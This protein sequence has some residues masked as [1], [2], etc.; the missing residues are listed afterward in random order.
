MSTSQSFFKEFLILLEI[1]GE[2]FVETFG[3]LAA[4]WWLAT[5][6]VSI[7]IN[8]PVTRIAQLNCNW[9][10]GF[11]S[12][13]NIIL[14]MT[15]FHMKCFSK[16]VKRMHLVTKKNQ[17]LSKGSQIKK[18]SPLLE[19]WC[20]WRGTLQCGLCYTELHMCAHA[21]LTL[22]ND[23]MIVDSQGPLF[24]QNNPLHSGLPTQ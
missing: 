14:E 13:K 5:Y 17:S 18:W 10:A 8:L 1:L 12:T 23:N 2:T 21:K 7:C 9:I 4:H 22:S 3:K 19:H 11:S 24:L 6:W 16:C 20:G 15:N